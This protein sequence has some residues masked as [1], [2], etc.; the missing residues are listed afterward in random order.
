MREEVEI[1]RDPDTTTMSI[2]IVAK[3]KPRPGQRAERGGSA[4]VYGDVDPRQVE[5]IVTTLVELPDVAEVEVIRHGTETWVE[6]E[7][8]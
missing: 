5:R 3:R 7:Y 1:L 6:R 4:I 8:R 2:K